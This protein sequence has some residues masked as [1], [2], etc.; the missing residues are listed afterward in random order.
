MNY[1]KEEAREIEMLKVEKIKIKKTVEAYN[2]MVS[3]MR[4]M[5]G[6][7]EYIKLV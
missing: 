7:P 2:D 5:A 1:T 6:R 4:K 3:K